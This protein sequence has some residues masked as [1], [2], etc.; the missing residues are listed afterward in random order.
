VRLARG[1]VALLPALALADDP[2]WPPPPVQLQPSSV[3]GALDGADA[4]LVLHY[5]LDVAGPKLLRHGFD[6]AIPQD[7][8]VTGA[9][10][11]IGGVSHALP[12]GDAATLGATF[13]ELG[14]ADAGAQP[15]WAVRIYRD[16]MND[17]SVSLDV[18]VPRRAH[19]A[20]ELQVAVAT[21][22][23]HDAR[24][25]AIDPAW[26]PHVDRALRT[27]SSPALLA[28]CA[29]FDAEPDKIAWLRFASPI[30]GDQP[31]L[32]IIAD[33]VALSSTNIARVELDVGSHAGDVPADLYTVLVLDNSRSLDDAQRSEQR[34]VVAS[35]LAKAPSGHVQLVAVDRHARTLLPAW[36]VA[37]QVRAKVASI[38]AA[39]DPA[40]GSN[41]DEGLA[42]AARALDGQPGTHRVIVFTDEELPWRIAVDKLASPAGALVHAVALRGGTGSLERDDNSL[43]AKLAA[44]TEGVGF[45]T[46]HGDAA[47]ATELVRPIAIE[48]LCVT[49]P[50][51]R[52]T[53]PAAETLE[54]GHAREWS[55]EG[56]GGPI[57]ITGLVWNH[58]ID[59]TVMATD[60]HT[61]A[62]ARRL[63]APLANYDPATNPELQRLARAV[64]D[65]WSLGAT[66]DGSGGYAGRVTERETPGGYG[67]G[68]EDG[69]GTSGYGRAAEP[70]VQ[71]GSLAHQLER[72][73]ATCRHANSAQVTIDV[74]LTD[75]EIVDVAVHG[76]DEA[77]ITDAV[78]A[79]HIE[80]ARRGHRLEHIE[81]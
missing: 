32:A 26:R 11:T 30:A 49:A 5:E 40:N 6:L 58:A 50:G 77:C 1:L 12:L 10:V 36:S 35:Y 59:R 51:L 9:T 28:A 60:D 55:G 24:Y 45:A 23:F 53:C 75:N 27:A 19:V 16:M 14:S 8:V 42:T 43:L 25:V 38:V 67:C 81:L 63:V 80:L 76:G 41:L 71:L 3:R 22:Y 46:S 7:G 17:S 18:G 20:I 2:T 31:R 66:W 29:G 37:S 13:A 72:A 57:R 78:W 44:R 21:C 73:T 54:E 34:A 70:Q 61:L 65:V 15:A 52:L 33:R 74:E 69:P 79:A 4:A 56:S 39:L 48:K 68:C 64:D 47:D 62:L